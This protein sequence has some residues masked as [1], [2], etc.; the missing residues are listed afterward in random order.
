VFYFLNRRLDINYARVRST[1]WAFLLCAALLFL[2]DS[3]DAKAQLP[4]TV[5]G[6]TEVS[7]LTIYPGEPTYSAWGHSALRI[8]DPVTGLDAAFNYGTFDIT[9]PYFIPRFA[10]GDMLY[11]LS[12]DPTSALFRGA[13]YQKRSVVEQVL[14]LDSTQV[15]GIYALLL[16]NLKPENRLYQ[17][18]FVFDNCS[19]RLL[20]LLFSVDGIILPATDP[21]DSTIREMLDEFVHDRAM[22]DLGIDLV[23]GSR[24]DVAPTLRER[25]F[26]PTYLMDVLDESTTPAGAAIVTEKRMV[27]E[28]DPLHVDRALPWTFWVNFAWVAIVLAWWRGASRLP[29]WFDRWLLGI[30][31]FVGLF[32]LGMWFLTLHHVTAANWNI[33]WA[34][35]SH[36]VFSLFWKRLSFKRAY[37]RWAGVWTTGIAIFSVFQAQHI[38]EA[39]WPVVVLLVLR[40]LALSIPEAHSP[41]SN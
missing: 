15:A 14:S 40:L 19:T 13:S 5:S 23:I 22:L 35:P 27:L 41:A 31:G 39:M 37:F 33:A 29:A 7:I 34:L 17:Y 6:S 4:P 20:D 2:F 11:Q 32:L 18:D 38:P 12:A 9:V 3:T 30:V 8:V 16:E 28:Y 36:L 24:L 25:T 26:L 1:F 21:Y 10:Y